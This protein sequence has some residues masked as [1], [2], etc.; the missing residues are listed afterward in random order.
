MRTRPFFRRYVLAISPSLFFRTHSLS[1][2]TLHLPA[3]PSS[4]FRSHKG[5]AERHR[6]PPSRDAAK[7]KVESVDKTQVTSSLC[8]LSLRLYV[9]LSRP[10]SH[11]K[12]LSLSLY[13]YMSCH[14]HLLILPLCFREGCAR[15]QSLPRAV[16]SLRPEVDFLICFLNDRRLF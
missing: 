2:H 6:S 8:H 7:K 16:R 13:I 14:D 4:P 10:P 12:V 5:C 9:P 1:C 11:P 3:P 15:R